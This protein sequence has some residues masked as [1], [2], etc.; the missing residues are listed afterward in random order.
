MEMLLIIHYFE[1]WRMIGE[2]RGRNEVIVWV[3]ILGIFLILGLC[4]G[5]DDFISGCI[6]FLCVLAKIGRN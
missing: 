1:G 2:L 4:S 3:I 6:R 5:G